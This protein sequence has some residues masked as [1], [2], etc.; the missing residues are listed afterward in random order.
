[1]TSQMSSLCWLKTSTIITRTHECTQ[2]WWILGFV[3]LNG[4]LIFLSIIMITVRQEFGACLNQ[5][6]RNNCIWQNWLDVQYKNTIQ[7]DKYSNSPRSFNC[8]EKSTICL[9]QQRRPIP[10]SKVHLYILELAGSSK[11][12]ASS[13]H[14]VYVMYAHK[15]WLCIFVL[16]CGWQ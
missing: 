2:K 12:L 11:S 6:C 1:M 16:S 3:Y 9:T 4:I 7:V 5:C 15:Q 10:Y 13:S 8:N 14:F